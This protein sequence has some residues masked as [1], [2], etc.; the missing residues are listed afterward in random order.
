MQKSSPK[1]QPGRQCPDLQ[2]SGA[3]LSQPQR[4]ATARPLKPLAFGFAFF[5]LRVRT[6][7][8]QDT[9][10]W[11]MTDRTRQQKKLSN[12]GQIS[13]AVPA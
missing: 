8:N 7:Q 11:N 5:V 12:T 1:D 10:D 2:F 13:L 3:R 6:V 4:M 9:T